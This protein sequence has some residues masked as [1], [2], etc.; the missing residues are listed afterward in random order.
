M[1]TNKWL[2]LLVVA[3]AGV[4]AFFY[5]GNRN[6]TLRRELSDFAVQDTAAIDRIFLADKMG[7]HVTLEKERPG[8]WIVD[9]KARAK[10][11]MV[12]TL[13]ATI[14]Q[15]DVRSPVAKAAF[16]N[17]MK[18]MAAT[19]VKTEIY[20]GGKKIKTYYVGHE[21]QDQYGTFM[22]LEHSS[23]PFVMHIPGF[24]GYL[25]SRYDAVAQDWV[26]NVVFD[27]APEEIEELTSDNR[28]APSMSFTLRRNGT[29]GY[30]LFAGTPQAPLDSVSDDKV[31][32]YLG[33]FGFLNYEFT[34][35]GLPDERLD[36]IRQSSPFLVLTVKGRG[37][38]RRASLYRMPLRRSK[39][40]LVDMG[41][42]NDKPYD[43]DRL[44]VR[45]DDDTTMH[46]A[47]YYSFG[48]LFIRPEGLLRTPPAGPR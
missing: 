47:Q 34:A 3:L 35:K 27:Y 33:Y 7:N 1:K 44:Y 37:T 26:P 12:N 18:K 28:E 16:N 30:D 36:S 10:N 45:L 6:S 20:A 22:Y 17:V 39:E 4:A 29:G 23:V 24:D 5:L 9:G 41:I 2:A 13:L 48:K 40:D 46:A 21:T 15:I 19:S 32:Q 38:E 14:T 25:T 43:T 8:R 42:M 11:D 31:Q